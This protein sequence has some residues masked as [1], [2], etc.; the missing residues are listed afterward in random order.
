MW[1]VFWRKIVDLMNDGFVVW[2]C[3]DEGC[4]EWRPAVCQVSWIR[5]GGVGTGIVVESGDVMFGLRWVAGD[6][7]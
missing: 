2:I 1:R 7:L 3:D 6:D 4:E 5:I